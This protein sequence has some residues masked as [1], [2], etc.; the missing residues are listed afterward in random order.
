MEHPREAAQ[1]FEKEELPGD[2]KQL[3]VGHSFFLGSD[4]AGFFSACLLSLETL[5]VTRCNKSKTDYDGSTLR[6]TIDGRFP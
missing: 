3:T 2:K 6:A 1:T 4:V 5:M